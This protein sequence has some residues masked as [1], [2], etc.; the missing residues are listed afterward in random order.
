[1]TK[2]ARFLVEG[3]NADESKCAILEIFHQTPS[4][5]H[6]DRQCMIVGSSEVKL[7]HQLGISRSSLVGGRDLVPW[8]ALARSEYRRDARGLCRD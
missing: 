5:G 7:R 3:R 4:A 6:D 1:M 8:L 2:R